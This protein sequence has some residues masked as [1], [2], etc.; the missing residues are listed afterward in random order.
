MKYN[1]V[2]YIDF[3]TTSSSSADIS[4]PANIKCVHVKNLVY[5]CD[6]V[7]AAGTAFY[8]TVTSSLVQGTPL[9]VVFEDSTYPVSGFQDI[10][11][12]YQTPTPVSGSYTFNLTGPSGTPFISDG[13]CHVVAVL[14]FNTEDEYLKHL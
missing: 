12:V 8:I 4:V 1:R 10:E 5:Q 13:N 11:F 7:P 14:E 3:S 9:G 6:T 2:V